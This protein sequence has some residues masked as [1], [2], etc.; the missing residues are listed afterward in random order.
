M[1]SNARLL[2]RRPVGQS[3]AYNALERGN[4]ALLVVY[5]Q[6]DAI[7]IAEVELSDIAMQMLLAAVLVNVLYAA[8]EHAVEALNGVRMIVA[9]D[10]FALTVA[11]ETVGRE[12]L[13]QMGIL[14][15]LI[16]HNRRAGQHV[17]FDDRQQVGGASA[18]NVEGT[19]GAAALDQGHY[20]MLVGV[21]TEAPSFF[22]MKFCQF[23]PS[24]PLRRT[25]GVCRTP[26]LRGCGAS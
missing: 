25:A 19:G 13:V 12:V 1:A 6:S 5:A 20:G 18:V 7:V 14:A 16:G 23:Q 24:F 17:G 21:A 22:P 26:W 15:S 3:L 2:V 4:S 11:G 10:V 9:T 8:L